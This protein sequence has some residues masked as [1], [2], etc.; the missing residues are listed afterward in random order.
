[1]KQIE[2]S[3]NSLPTMKTPVSNASTDEFFQTFKKKI[4]QIFCK[5]LQ[6]I[7]KERPFPNL[8]YEAK[9]TL[10]PKQKASQEKKTTD[11]YSS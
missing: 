8:A 3:V 2:F 11:C 6:K 7:K 10:I 1:M 5:F 9:V 4:I